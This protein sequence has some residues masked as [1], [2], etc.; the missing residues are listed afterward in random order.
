MEGYAP[1]PAKW[2]KRERWLEFPPMPDAS[3]PAIQDIASNT[4]E[5]TEWM[6]FL[7]QLRS[8]HGDAVCRSWF[9]QLSLSD[10]QGNRLTMQAP[11][12]FVSEWVSNHYAADIVQA[13]QKIWPDISVVRIV[14]SRSVA[15]PEK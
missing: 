5:N 3:P 7:E 1:Y 11:T 6:A 14:G 12:R 13:A 10:K 15:P 8:R 2:L 9:S 4:S